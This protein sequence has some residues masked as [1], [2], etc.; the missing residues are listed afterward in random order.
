MSGL[1][2]RPSPFLLTCAVRTPPHAF[3]TCAANCSTSVVLGD[4]LEQLRTELWSYP[5]CW[6][7]WKMLGFLKYPVVVTAEVNLILMVLTVVGLV[8]RL[9]GLTHPH[10]VVFDEVYYG[11]FI[12]LYMKQIFFLDDS[13]PPLGHM[14][15][16]LGGYMGGF[17]GNFLWNRIGAEYSNNVPVWSLRFLPAVAGGLCVPIVYQ[18]V[19]ELHFSHSTALGAALLI[20]LE[21]SLITQSRLMLLESIL[22]FFI[23]LAVLS[24][25][26]FHNIQK[27]SSFSVAYWFWLMLT[28]VT[29][30]CA[31]G[32]KYMGLFTYLLLLAVAGIHT[33]HVIGNK[34]LSNMTVLCHVLARGLAVLVTPVLMYLGFF[35]IH[36]VLLYRSGPH[37]QI[38]SSAFQAS[39]EG[40]LAR[41]TQGQPLEVAYG[42]Q[43][44]MRNVLSKPLPCW[45][46]SHKSTYPVRYEDGR[47]SSHQQQVTCYPFKDVN[48]WWIVKNPGLQQMVV[49][50]PPRSVRHGD[51]VQLVHGIT[52]RFL[53]THDV[54]APLSPFA[55][56]VSCYIDYNVSMPSQN[57]WRLDIVNRESDTEVWK[58]I[59]SE[60]K[61][62]HVNTSAVLKLSGASLPDWGYRQL[63]IVGDKQ[64]TSSHQS[65]TWTVEEHRYGKSQE[66]EEREL[67]LQTPTQVDLSRNLSFMAR[68]L[69]L[70]W[71]MLTLQNEYT[72][73]KYSSSPVDW[74]TMD[75]SIAYW[76]QPTS[77]AQIQLLGNAVIWYAAS[78]GML[79]YIVLSLWYL[80]RRQR[81][82]YDIPEGCWRS[83]AL[84]GALCLGGWAV[85]YLPFFLM[86]KTLFLYHYLPALTFQ[87]LLLPIVLQHLHDHVLRT[88][89][90]KKMLSALVVAGFSSVFLVYRTFSPLTYGQP[91]LSAAE[92]QDLRWKESWD[93]LVRKR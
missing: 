44:T 72:E 50:N 21:N 46:H 17:D 62:V 16:A 71:K 91:A 76:L 39:L 51:I 28:G 73:H 81:R 84:A 65:L 86:E 66:Q 89:A 18:I 93:I 31:V 57:L 38:M 11:Q 59:L 64:S 90:L 88:E 40:G 87:I 82:I 12:S 49:S 26:K 52:A 35:Y 55:Q 78:A 22:I 25:L 74:I 9:W 36:L 92:L 77:G 37:D 34:T 6:G 48:N 53:N 70:Q 60:V 3:T 27:N 29:C 13:G 79:V 80:L 30:A 8:S 43:V 2:V 56:E 14:L 75:T 42:S 19:L 63:E 69:E 20:L 47:G 45:L 7:P 58:T 54:A 4:R 5:G 33:W 23:L 24:Y 15:L 41:I 61:L 1:T 67:E 32:V 85:N 83:W 10:A 68:F